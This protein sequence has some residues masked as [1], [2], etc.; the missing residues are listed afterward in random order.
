MALIQS[1][2]STNLATVDTTGSIYTTIYPNVGVGAYQFTGVSGTIAASTAANS[3]LFTFKNNGTN[4]MVIRRFSVGLQVTTAFTK[5][6]LRLSTYFV[7]TSFTQ[8][9]TN[10]TLITLTGNNG[11]KRTSQPTTNAV[12]YICTTAGITGDTATGEDTTAFASAG[13]DLPAAIG[14]VPTQGL[15]D[16][17]VHTDTEYPLV[18][19]PQEGFRLKNDTAFAA[20][21]SGN[22]IVNIEYG[23]VASYA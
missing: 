19:A 21:G 13:L 10:G 14:N 22:L 11:K 3:I 2:L 9:T 15:Y 12:G 5:G 16:M 7:R 6:S 8:G 17:I 20:T 23:E 4:L 18:L 1:G